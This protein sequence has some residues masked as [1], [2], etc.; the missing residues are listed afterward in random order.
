MWK[1]F[2][3]LAPLQLDPISLAKPGDD[4]AAAWQRPHPY[5]GSHG[6]AAPKQYG[7]WN[8]SATLSDRHCARAS[9]VEQKS[10]PGSEVG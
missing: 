7:W 4:S 2:S 9:P 8:A 10:I 3:D 5:V 1:L 6:T